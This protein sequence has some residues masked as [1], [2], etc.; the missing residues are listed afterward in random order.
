MIYAHASVKFH[1][2][3]FQPKNAVLIFT[4]DVTPEKA[5]ELMRL[6]FESEKLGDLFSGGQ[7]AI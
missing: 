1:K 3:Y 6:G 4:G 5:N 7:V 2:D